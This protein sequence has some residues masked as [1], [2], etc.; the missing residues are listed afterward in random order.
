[1]SKCKHLE[2]KIKK[3]WHLK[4]TPAPLVVGALGMI[5]KWIDK[6]VDKIPGNPNLYEILNNFTL[7]SCS[8]P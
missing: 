4:T 2:I 7:P 8:S 5:K 3:K 6:H 1:M